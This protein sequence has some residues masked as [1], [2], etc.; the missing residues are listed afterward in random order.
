M[1]TIVDIVIFGAGIAG[2]WTF[3]RLRRAGYDVLLL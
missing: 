1:G 3:N 2:L